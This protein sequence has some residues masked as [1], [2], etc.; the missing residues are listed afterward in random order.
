MRHRGRWASFVVGGAALAVL[1]FVFVPGGGFRQRGRPVHGKRHA[2]LRRP[3]HER[4]V[5]AHNHER[6]REHGRAGLRPD[7]PPFELDSHSRCDYDARL[8]RDQF[9]AG[10]DDG[11][12][13]GAELAGGASASVDITASSS[14]RS[15]DTWSTDADSSAGFTFSSDGDFA[16]T[17][18]DPV[19]ITTGTGD[20]SPACGAR[21][22]PLP[23][24]ATPTT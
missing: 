14:A 16:V 20:S 8:E 11:A 18:S 10:R 12:V 4:H 3:G 7:H 22:P 17:G 1:L 2:G 15:S 23:P 6:R 24:R 9:A 13:Q 21:A 19:V 5:Q